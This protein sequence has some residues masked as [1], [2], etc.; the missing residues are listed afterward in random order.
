[1]ALIAWAGTNMLRID[2]QGHINNFASAFQVFTM[3]TVVGALLYGDFSSTTDPANR[4]SFNQV[5][6]TYYNGTGFESVLYVCCIGMVFTAYCFTGY[7]ASSH[8]AEETV[9]R[10]F[11]YGM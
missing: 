9:V 10:L 5:F 6:F 4:A 1:M 8:M 2:R 7:E 11:V 3:I